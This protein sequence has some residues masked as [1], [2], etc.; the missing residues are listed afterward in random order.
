MKK[1]WSLFTKYLSKKQDNSNSF[2]KTLENSTEVVEQIKNT[3]FAIVHNKE[4]QLYLLTIANFKL[5]E[6]KN[7]ESLLLEIRK[8]N[9]MLIADLIAVIVELNDKQKNR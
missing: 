5:R 9:W 3:P 1:V 8:V 7:K 4:K 2:S 6:S